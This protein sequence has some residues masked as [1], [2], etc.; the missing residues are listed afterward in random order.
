MNRP[1]LARPGPTVTLFYALYLRTYCRYEFKFKHNVCILFKIVLSDFQP[2]LS[3][4]VKMVVIL[5]NIDF[6]TFFDIFS[7]I[8]QKL[9]R[10]SDFSLFHAKERWNLVLSHY[11]DLWKFKFLFMKN[12]IL[13][14]FFA[15]LQYIL[16]HLFKL[17]WN[18]PNISQL[19]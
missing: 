2:V 9:L 8:T 14:N 16:R 18:C 3:I 6:R 12:T 7:L 13:C 19:V 5:V 15:I 4:N 11:R 1:D 17:F 10:F